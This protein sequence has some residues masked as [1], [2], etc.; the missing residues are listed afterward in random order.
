[1][2]NMNETKISKDASGKKLIVTRDFNA[3]VEKVW[4]AWTDSSILDTWW[5]P[6]PWRAVT[7]SMDFS[8]GGHW[9]YAMTSPEGEK[10]WC[11]VDYKTIDAPKNFTADNGFC[12]EHGNTTYEAPLM[13]WLVQFAS[14]GAGTSI[15]VDIG[16][17]SE[18]DLE[19][20][21][22]MGFKEGFTMGLN[23]L[24]EVLAG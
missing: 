1:M 4:R 10:H 3:P 5:A 16:F 18:A 23:N 22:A 6:R 9:M 13:H 20:I 21:V 11:K 14:S 24:D 15:T 19:K 7:K 2:I 12:D 8:E 17:D